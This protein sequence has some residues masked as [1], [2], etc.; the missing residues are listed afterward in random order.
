MEAMAEAAEQLRRE[1]EPAAEAEAEPEQLSGG[2]RKRS[3]KLYS[4]NPNSEIVSRRNYS[5]TSGSA[6]DR[7]AD[8]RLAE[9]DGWPA[10]CDGR[11]GPE[12]H[13]MGLQPTYMYC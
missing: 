2:K 10:C 5:D 11:R 1:A 13:L 3:T 6:H 4:H 8:G 12:S 7:D 9:G